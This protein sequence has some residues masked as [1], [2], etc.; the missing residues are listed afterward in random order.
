MAVRTTRGSSRFRPGCGRA[1]LDGN[2]TG[3]SEHRKLGQAE[4]PIEYGVRAAAEFV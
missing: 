1:H 2:S 3:M 4:V